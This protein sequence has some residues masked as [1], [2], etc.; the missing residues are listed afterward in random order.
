MYAVAVPGAVVGGYV[1]DGTSGALAC[2]AA[3][4]VVLVLTARAAHRATNRQRR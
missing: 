2:L 4:V 3:A 1:I